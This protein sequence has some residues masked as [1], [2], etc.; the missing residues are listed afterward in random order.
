MKD[1]PLLSA[2]RNAGPFIDTIDAAL[3]LGA[4]ET[5]WCEQ[6]ASFKSIAEKFALRTDARPSSFVPEEEAR[7][8]GR[9]VLDTLRQRIAGWFNLRLHGELDYPVRLRDA[10]YPVELLYFQGWWDLI[11]TPSVAVVGTRQPSSDGKKRAQKLVK[12]LLKDDFTIISGL[13]EGIDTVAHET[14]IGEGGQTI[15]VIGTPLGHYYP[16][17]NT[18]LQDRIAEEFLLI[19]QIPVERYDAQNPRTN[20]YFFP[21]RNKTMSALAQATIIVE[22]G[23]TSGTLTQAREALKQGRKL[24]I[25]N[26][27]FENPDLTW[28]AKYEALG[29]IRVREY[30]DIRRELVQ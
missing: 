10:T 25:L 29:A 11:D 9:R 5:L 6:N 28:P 14:A 20:R 8:A 30:D 3:E 16:K 27:C 17:S 2:R 12:S 21:E 4:Y 22:A 7:N 18:T 23:E 19:S 26:N 15:A 24:F 1:T 13:A